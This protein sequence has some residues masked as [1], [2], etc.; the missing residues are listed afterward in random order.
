MPKAELPLFQS[1]AGKLRIS[2]LGPLTVL[3]VDGQ[4]LALTTT[5]DFSAVEKWAKTKAAAPNAPL[6]VVKILAKVAVMVCRPIGGAS[7]G[8]RG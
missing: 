5:A 4:G 8:G 2:R 3:V 1:A 7:G 6:S